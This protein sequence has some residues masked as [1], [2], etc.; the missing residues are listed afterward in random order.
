L[1]NAALSIV[2]PKIG[3]LQNHVLL[4]R[5]RPMPARSAA[6][7]L[8][9]IRG[10]TRGRAPLAAAGEAIRPLLCASSSAPS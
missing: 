3:M 5:L 7:A 6:P 10:R 1:L 4:A 2:H 8:V 9:R